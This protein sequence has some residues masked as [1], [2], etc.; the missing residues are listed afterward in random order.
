MTGVRE[1]TYRCGNGFPGFTGQIPDPIPQVRRGLGERELLPD[2][3]SQIAASARDG[4]VQV[5]SAD[6]QSQE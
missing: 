1:S 6:W 4:P 3:R 5:E 2:D